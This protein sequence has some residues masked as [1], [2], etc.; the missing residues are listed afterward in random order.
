MHT[1]TR[2]ALIGLALITAFLLAACSQ[3]ATYPTTAYVPLTGD[4][5]ARVGTLNQDHRAFL[6]S[7]EAQCASDKPVLRQ[8]NVNGGSVLFEFNIGHGTSK[9]EIWV[10]KR[11]NEYGKPPRYVR[12]HLFEVGDGNPATYQSSYDTREI[13][14]EAHYYAIVRQV[15]CGANIDTPD[16][17]FSDPKEFTIGRPDV[18]SACANP[19]AENG[20]CTAKLED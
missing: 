19:W 14:E 3:P 10:F 5:S 18:P 4:G 20:S 8:A 7:P 13:T 16:G 15:K 6:G 17:P 2:D 1:D 12:A 9:A 11:I